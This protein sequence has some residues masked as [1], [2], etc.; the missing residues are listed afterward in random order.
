MCGWPKILI[1]S[2][3][4]DWFN[5]SFSYLFSKKTIPWFFWVF[6]NWQL[7]SIIDIKKTIKF[8]ESQNRKY[9]EKN[10]ISIL[11]CNTAYPTPINNSNLLSIKKFANIFKKNI[12]YSDHTIGDFVPLMS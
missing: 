10:M 3:I 7:L 8:T 5:I 6:F 11:H 12:G 1:T 2:W 4:F 9:K